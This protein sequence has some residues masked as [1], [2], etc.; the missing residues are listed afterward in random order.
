VQQRALIVPSEALAGAGVMPH[1]GSWA[2]RLGG[3]DSETAAVQQTVDVPAPPTWR[4]G[5]R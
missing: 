5:S 2:A 3:A 4:T 1:S